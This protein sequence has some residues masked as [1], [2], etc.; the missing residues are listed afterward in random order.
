MKATQKRLIS[1]LL[2]VVLTLS[3][4]A[5]TSCNLLSLI[6][7]APNDGGTGGGE[8]GSQSGGGNQSGGDIYVEGGDNNDITINLND[9]AS[10]IAASKAILSVV[11]IYAEFERTY[12]SGW[13]PGYSK[14]EEFAQSGAGVIY[15]LDKNKGDAYIITNYHVIHSSSDN[16]SSQIARRITLYLYGMEAAEY[17][18][19]AEFVG[20]SMQY[21]L[22]VLKVSASPVLISSIAMATTVA[23]SNDVAVLDTAIAIGNPD[24]NGISATVGYVNVDSEEIELLASDDKTTVK[25]RVMRIDAA[26]N[27][28]NSGGGLFNSKGELIGIVNAK[29]T[30]SDGMGYAI[31]SNVAKYIAEN[32]LYYCDGTDKTSVQRCLLGITVTPSELYTVYDDETG[33]VHRCE[34]VKI[35]EITSSSLAS[36]ALQVGDVINS[37]TID[38]TTYSV[39]RLFHVVDSML[40]ARVGSR[41]VVNVDRGG[42]TIDVSLEITESTLTEY[43]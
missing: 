24:T 29:K 5:M 41:V 37:I 20:G 33:R 43:K 17:A 7:D 30:T 42:A 22:A 31:P 3:C 18:I 19:P 26:I 16:S 36:E 4:L 14:T 40:N 6:V 23:D 1:L 12:T 27:G 13:G 11:S 2:A 21:D 32:I 39:T 35:A 38:G 34:R 28:G 25:I 9:S 10:A 15:K 8:G